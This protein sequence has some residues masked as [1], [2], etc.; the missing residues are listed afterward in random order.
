VLSDD[1]CIELFG[2][3]GTVHL[4]GGGGHRYSMQEN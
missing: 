4:G 2:S 1:W 3:S